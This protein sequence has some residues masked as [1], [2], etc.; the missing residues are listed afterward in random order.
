MGTQ[1]PHD[2]A[3]AHRR[4]DWV[5]NRDAVVQ[6]A[7]ALYAEHGYDVSFEQIAH[8]AGIGR[9]TLYRHFQTRERLRLAVVEKIVEEIE[10]AAV[11]RPD[12]PT[13]FRELFKLAVRLQTETLPV[14]ELLPASGASYPYT[15]QL[16]ERTRQAFGRPLAAAQAAG[17]VAPDIEPE[18][19]RLEL[20]MLAAVI[21]PDTPAASRH[22][23]WRLAE[24]ALGIA[25]SA[26]QAG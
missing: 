13:T 19:V 14:T 3:A 9:A 24:A 2:E 15:E 4:A 1:T 5:A 17:L 23:A 7:R 8:R 6:A 12:S 16:R 21:R 25:A 10:A 18:D 11:H 20:V 22:R 26:T